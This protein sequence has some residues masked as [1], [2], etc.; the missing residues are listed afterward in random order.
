MNT[1]V[2]IPYTLRVRAND[3]CKQMEAIAGCDPATERRTRQAVTARTM[4]CYALLLK[5]YTEHAIG[6]IMGWDHSTINHYRK[7]M[8]DFLY[9]PGY[10][11][12]RELWNKF[13]TA[14]R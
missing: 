6:A 9:T 3:Y 13:K 8:Y 5:G 7:K 11:A 4:V 12:E 10:D 14:I 1:P 2:L